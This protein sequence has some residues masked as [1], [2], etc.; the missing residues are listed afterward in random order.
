MLSR[1]PRL[2]VHSLKTGKS[3]LYFPVFIFCEAFE[4]TFSDQY[5]SCFINCICFFGHSTM[6]MCKIFS[7]RTNHYPTA[8]NIWMVACYENIMFLCLRRLNNRKARLAR[9]AK[10]VRPALEADNVLPD[11]QGGRG[12]RSNNSPDTP[13]GDASSQLNV[14]R[15]P[16][17]M[18]RTGIREISETNVAEAAVPRGPAEFDLCKQGDSIGLMGANGEEIGRG[19]VFQVRGQ[20]YGRN[21]EELRAYV[22]DVKELKARRATRLPHPSVAT[23]VSFEEAETKIGVMRVLWDSNMTFTLR[24]KRAM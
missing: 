7:H 6:F 1:V 17:I 3:S 22:V 10:D 18:L 2:H 15:D 19:K 16:Q 21:L 9:T 5:G 12:L 14:R 13:G 11:K 20:W 24:P 8:M 23:G 4:T